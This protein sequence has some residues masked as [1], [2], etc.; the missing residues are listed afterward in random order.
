MNIVLGLRAIYGNP[1]YPT[2]F[3]KRQVSLPATAPF[4]E[5]ASQQ[6]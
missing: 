6:S 4:A 3:G 5:G 1:V 2:P